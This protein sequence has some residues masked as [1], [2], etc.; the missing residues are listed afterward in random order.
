[1]KR[2]ILLMTAFLGLTTLQSQAQSDSKT[3]TKPATDKQAGQAKDISPEE[4]AE[5]QTKRA[6][7][8]LGL[9]TDQQ[10]KFKAFALERINTMRPIREKIRTTEDKAER[11]K[12]H[13]ESKQVAEKFDANVK[14][15]LTAEQLPKW[16]NRKD[17][18]LEKRKVNRE[19]RQKNQDQNP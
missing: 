18:A 17:E 4:Q 2:T 1:M 3:A 11:K 6:T 15:I 10:T 12:L 9:T 7:A 14:S 16:E 19:M 13:D 5:R 8:D